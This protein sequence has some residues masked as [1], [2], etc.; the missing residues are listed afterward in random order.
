MTNPMVVPIRDLTIH[1][2]VPTVPVRDLLEAAGRVV[3]GFRRQIPAAVG[4]ELVQEAVLR[5]LKADGVRE[6]RAFVRRVAR[7]L[8][9][10]HL[11]RSREVAVA[12]LPDVDSGWQHRT[13]TDLDVQRVIR[14]LQRAPD[15]YRRTIEALVFQGRSVED[16]VE[17]EVVA[18]GEDPRDP[19]CRARARDVVYKRR[20][21][22]YGWIRLTLRDDVG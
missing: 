4:D 11:R 21:R 10:D 7:H 17:D 3:G 13:D 15:A 14:I 18:R 12:E 5:Y 8:A 6:P 16:L 1:P 20:T 22:A 19:A 2:P 9:I